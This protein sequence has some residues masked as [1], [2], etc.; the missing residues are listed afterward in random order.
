MLRMVPGS[1]P[2]QTFRFVG[3][4]VP[5]RR[6]IGCKIGAM[7]STPGTAAKRWSGPL[8]RQRAHGPRGR[9]QNG[10]LEIRVQFP[11]GPLMRDYGR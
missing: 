10:I 1:I 7:G 9:H 5:W 8:Q 2:G 4:H 11:V 3:W 6:L